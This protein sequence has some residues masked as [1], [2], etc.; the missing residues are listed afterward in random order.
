MEKLIE[1]R[2]QVLEDLEIEMD[3]CEEFDQES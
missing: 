3:R 2:K 1:V